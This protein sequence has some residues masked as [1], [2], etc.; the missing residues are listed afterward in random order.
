[1]FD[2]TTF[3]LRPDLSDENL[4]NAVSAMSAVVKAL[5]DDGPAESPTVKAAREILATEN[6]VGQATTQVLR[7]TVHALCVDFPEQTVS[8]YD[9]LTEIRDS[10]KVHRDITLAEQVRSM[11]SADDDSDDESTGGS[12]SD[13]EGL[14]DFIISLY[15]A[16]NAMGMGV[17]EG[18]PVKV[19]DKTG[20]TLPDLPRIPSGP[21]DAGVVVGRGANVRKL[22]ITV[23]GRRQ[24]ENLDVI[25]ARLL[26]TP[27][28]TYTGKDLLSRVNAQC[29]DP[30]SGKVWEINVNGHTVQGILP[31]KSA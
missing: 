19:S 17:P 1:M 9:L 2:P 25:C 27:Y 21:R 16:R 30:F 24:T 3:N 20:E 18:F 13:A 23:D 8:L 26:S 6:P 11:K 5:K 12:K 22:V 14:R 7:E 4:L 10:V 28:V 31:G 15:N 29:G